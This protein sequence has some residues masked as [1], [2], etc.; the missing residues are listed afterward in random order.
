MSIK[1]QFLYDI[2]YI[3][4]NTIQSKKDLMAFMQ[5]HDSSSLRY[6]INTGLINVS[7]AKVLGITD[8]QE[9]YLFFQCGLFHDVGKLGMS[10]EFLNYP[11]SYSLQMYNEMKKHTVGGADILQK[12]NADPE[13]IAT[14]RYHHCNYD[15][16]GYPGGLFE[17][18]IPLTARI[19]RISDSVDAYLSKRC[20]K[21]GG[22][23]KEVWED[24]NQFSG[25]SYD[26][27]LLQCFSA[28]H[29]KIMYDCHVIGIDQPSQ[30]L[31]MYK[32]KE[33]FA[34]EFEGREKEVE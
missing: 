29:S 34:S 10:Y 33:L 2:S 16:T 13:L 30:E 6:C 3:D 21:D 9:L 7:I 32:L 5:K 19:T 18:E 15:G 14:A 24:L 27:A 25:T 11:N 4:F 8:E 28:V 31:Y 20:Y 22:P 23:T 17:D 1:K 26:P 12:I